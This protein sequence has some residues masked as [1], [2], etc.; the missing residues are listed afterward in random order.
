MK[1]K[2]AIDIEFTE[3]IAVPEIMKMLLNLDDLAFKMKMRK[4]LFW[5]T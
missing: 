4:I 3:Q 2:E 5:L 1:M